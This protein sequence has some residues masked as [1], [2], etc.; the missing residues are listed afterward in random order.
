LPAAGRDVTSVPTLEE[1]ADLIRANSANTNGRIDSLRNETNAT[2]MNIQ[3]D[4]TDVRGEIKELRSDADETRRGLTELKHDVGE[5]KRDVAEVKRN[6]DL[7]S[8][9]VAMRKEL[10]VLSAE[11][12]ELK[13]RAS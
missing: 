3:N 12:A 8:T 11:V 13:R 9:V 7:T 1:L 2:L 10:D 5:L 4:F 6:L